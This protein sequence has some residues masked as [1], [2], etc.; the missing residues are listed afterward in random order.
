MITQEQMR[1]ARA[2][3]VNE[4]IKERDHWTAQ[5]DQIEALSLQRYM[6]ACDAKSERD[7][8]KN[9]AEAL[10]KAILTDENTE[11]ICFLCKHSREP[12]SECDGCGISENF[13]FWDLD[14]AR[15]G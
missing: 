14:E 7:Y 1:E 13:D 6:D 5:V 2:K 8:W 4:L 9:R 11:R 3:R 15:F 10:K 12:E